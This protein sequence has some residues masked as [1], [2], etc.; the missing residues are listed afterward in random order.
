MGEWLECQRRVGAIIIGQ[1]PLGEVIPFY[2]SVGRRGASQGIGTR[3]LFVVD[4]V[5]CTERDI[6]IMKMLFCEGRN[7]LA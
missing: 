5:W 2:P 6:H 1:P 7:G 4:F 3:R